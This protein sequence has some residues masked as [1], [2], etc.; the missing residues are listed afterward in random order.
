M[1]R[2]LHY[3][4]NRKKKQKKIGNN[5]R[6]Y[7]TSKTL[8]SQINRHY[9]LPARLHNRLHITACACHRAYHDKWLKYQH[10]ANM[11][12]YQLCVIRE[13]KSLKQSLIFSFYFY[14]S[15]F[16]SFSI[17]F[18]RFFF[19]FLFLCGKKKKKQNFFEIFLFLFL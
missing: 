1:N 13:H 17:L 4:V 11:K 19:V 3:V 6:V 7:N 16:F 2:I 9:D 14:F 15:F 12:C 10:L 5:T 18:F 8:D